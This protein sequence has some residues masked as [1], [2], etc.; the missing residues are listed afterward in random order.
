MAIIIVDY[1]VKMIKFP[2]G[3]VREAVVE[4]EDGSYTI[5]IDET[6]SRQEQQKELLHALKHILGDD[7]S[8]SDVHSIERKAHD[9]EISVELCPIIAC[10]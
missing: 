5:F 6:L 1:H 10:T 4:N 9:M 7:F 8:K 2:N 3:K